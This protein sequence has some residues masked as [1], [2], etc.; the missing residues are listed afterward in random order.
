M[1]MNV[2]CTEWQEALSTKLRNAFLEVRMHNAQSAT[3]V[4]HVATSAEALTLYS[5]TQCLSLKQ[6][7]L[8]IQTL[9]TKANVLWNWP[10]SLIRF[11]SMAAPGLWG[12]MKGV[13]AF[14]PHSTPLL[15][16]QGVSEQQS[17]GMLLRTQDVD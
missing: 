6:F 3:Q 9:R 1:R 12:K 5:H 15:S 7:Q 8:F 13:V 17:R 4:E 2:T 10:A 11:F 16:P 14:S